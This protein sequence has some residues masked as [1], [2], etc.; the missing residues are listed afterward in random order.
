M[1]A[2]VYTTVLPWGER[3]RFLAD[4][5]EAGAMI[6]LMTEDDDAEDGY[7]YSSTPYQTADARHRERDA[8]RLALLAA[9]RE[10]YV[11][12]SDARPADMQLDA[13]V[14]SARITSEAQS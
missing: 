5:V 10:F 12:P 13:I 14:R 2:R 6:R 8:L 11:D 4:L 1:S 3:F 7:R 9:G